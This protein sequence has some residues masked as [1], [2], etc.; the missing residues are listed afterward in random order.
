[1]IQPSPFQRLLQDLSKDARIDPSAAFARLDEIYGKTSTET[2]LLHFIVYTT[3]LGVGA[4]GRYDDCETLLRRCFEHPALA[5]ESAVRRSLHR[6]LAV[7]LICA[8]RRKD[9]EAEARHGIIGPADECRFSGAAA[10]T[11][12]ARNRPSEAVPFL[13][14]AAALCAVVP[15]DDDV[16]VQTAGIASNLLRIAEPQCLLTQHL[17]TTAGDAL[18]AATMRNPD[19]LTHHRAL[20]NQGKAWLLAVNP[21]RAL[22]IVGE[23]MQL[24]RRNQAG[25]EQRFYSANLACRAQ[26]VRGQFK[27]ATSAMEACQKLVAECEAAGEPLGPAYEDL[28]RF[29]ASLQ[30]LKPLTPDISGAAPVLPSAG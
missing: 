24:E 6:A 14:R 3:N 29:V 22:A 23:M 10:Q 17:L 11:L 13:K 2:D 7:L 20:F 19:W 28:E 15:A 4:L 5:K 30:T 16:L 18:A 27:V 25:P 1:M 12:L 9:A 8:E 21:M 26:A